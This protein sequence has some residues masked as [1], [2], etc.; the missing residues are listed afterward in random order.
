MDVAVLAGIIIYVTLNIAAALL[1]VI[2]KNK[3]I[4][5]KWRV[6]EMSLLIAAFFGP[7][8]ATAAMIG[9]HHKTRKPKFKL[10]Y[11]FAVLHAI[12]IIYLIWHFY[13]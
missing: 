4:E 2:D 3:A 13:L 11:V 10:V 1:F 9:A 12:I 5:G 8:G 7:F 6:S